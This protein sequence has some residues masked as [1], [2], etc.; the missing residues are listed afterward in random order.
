MLVTGR[1]KLHL[2]ADRRRRL[3]QSFLEN[4]WITPSAEAISFMTGAARSDLLLLRHPVSQGCGLWFWPICIHRGWSTKFQPIACTWSPHTVQSP[5]LWQQLTADTWKNACT[6]DF[7]ILDLGNCDSWTT[8]RWLEIV[9]YADISGCYDWLVNTS[10][11][12]L[13]YSSE[14]TCFQSKHWRSLLYIELFHCESILTM[15]NVPALSA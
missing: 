12:V 9:A 6:N 3:L 10:S 2:F 4:T 15:D 13:I 7:F 11:D 8:H 5:A 14:S 1:T